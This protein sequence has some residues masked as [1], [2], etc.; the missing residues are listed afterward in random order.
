MEPF[1]VVKFLGG[2][3]IFSG[4]R[5]GKL[6]FY[7]ILIAVA[8]GIYH[9]TFLSR[10]IQQDIKANTVVIQAQDKNAFFFGVKLWKLK[11][12]ATVE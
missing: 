5:L 8:L 6:L 2:F 3:N 11:I 10:T 12:G 7:F 1:S 9:K 4:A